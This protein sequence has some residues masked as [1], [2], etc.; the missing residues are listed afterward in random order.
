LRTE[1]LG[2]VRERRIGGSAEIGTFQICEDDVRS[3]WKVLRDVEETGK[4]TELESSRKRVLQWRWMKACSMQEALGIDA[5]KRQAGRRKDSLESISKCSK[6]L[7]EQSGAEQR[8]VVKC[9]Q[10]REKETK[11]KQRSYLGSGI[12]EMRLEDCDE[13][14]WRSARSE[15]KLPNE[16]RQKRVKLKKCSSRRATCRQSMLCSATW[17]TLAQFD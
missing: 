8:L 10:V 1:D 15:V 17:K 11:K 14:R 5:D 3:Q 4:F 9:K 16:R 13:R 7:W 6:S 12:R 2:E